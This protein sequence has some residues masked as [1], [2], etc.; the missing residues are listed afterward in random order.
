MNSIPW[1]NKCLID[2]FVK[3]GVEKLMCRATYAWG[4]GIHKMNEVQQREGGKK[5]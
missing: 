5:T 3:G 4:E 2:D 1:Y